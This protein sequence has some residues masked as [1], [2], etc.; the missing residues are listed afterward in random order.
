[1]CRLSLWAESNSASHVSRNASGAVNASPRPGFQC[2]CGQSSRLQCTGSSSSPSYVGPIVAHQAAVVGEAVLLEQRER[3]GRELPARARGT[4]RRHV[5]PVSERCRPFRSLPPARRRRSRRSAC[6]G[7]RDAR[8]R[9]PRLDRLDRF[10]VA[11]GG[12]AG[13]VERRLDLVP[14]ED[15]EDPRE[16]PGDAEP[17]LAQRAQPPRV[18]G[19]APQPPDSAS[20]SKVNETATSAP[21]G[22]SVRM[23]DIL[24]WEGANFSD[25]ALHVSDMGLANHTG[26]WQVAAR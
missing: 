18:R 17:P 11:L 1:M 13:D 21:P 14:P 9:G 12:V 22:Q 8:S 7:T 23:S 6:A 19:I 10:R 4:P 2:R 26:K 20:T 15:L 3:L 25:R 24:S 16:A 5:Q